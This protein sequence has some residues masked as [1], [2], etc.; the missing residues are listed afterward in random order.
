MMI[1]YQASFT[2]RPSDYLDEYTA[3][4]DEL[5]T[6]CSTSNRLLSEENY[7]E[8]IEYFIYDDKVSS[9]LSRFLLIRLRR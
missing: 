8:T 3:V 9:L 5:Y 4:A 6:I 2:L 1:R 7:E